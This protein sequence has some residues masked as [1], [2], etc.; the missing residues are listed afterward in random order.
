MIKC[1]VVDD[2]AH[3][4]EL[5]TSYIEQIPFLQLV[6]SASNPME[7]LE[8]INTKEVDLVF[9]DIQMPQM[10]GIEFLPIVKDRTKVILT[11]AFREYALE[12]FEHNVVD[13]L[14]KPIFFPR[15]LTAVQRVQNTLSEV[16]AETEDF[17]L[18]KTELKGKLLKIKIKDILF[19]ESKGKYVSI[20][21]TDGQQTMTLLNIG[22]LEE[23]LPKEQFTRV[24]KSFIVAVSYII[25]IQGNSI[26]LE[27][28]KSAIPIGQSY[29]EVFMNQMTDKIITNKTKDQPDEKS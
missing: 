15:F 19:I 7:A 16:K 12:G 20:H 21:T 11:T 8:L 2:E 4:I 10:S 24:H 9:L 28:T 23:K 13:Y 25:M 14:L 29:R 1:I 18:V 3:A 17:I 22:T 26:H 27:F 6:G 5:L